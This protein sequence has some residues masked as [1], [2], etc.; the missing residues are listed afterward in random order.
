MSGAEAPR[1]AVPGR[2]LVVDDERQILRALSALLGAAGYSV[3]T[4]ATGA[5]A[6]QSAALSPPDAVVL[7]LRL[8]DLDG[9]E[10]CR[11]LR[12]WSQVPV[13]VV[14]VVDDEA[15]KVGALDAGADDY[16]TKPYSTA[17]LLAR[18]RAAMRRAAAPVGEEPQVS[19]G[20]VVVDLGR[21]EVR[22]GGELLHLTRRE[23]GLLAELARHP[24]RLLT[25]SMLLRAVW[26]PG[27]EE[28]SHYLHVHMSTL[29]RKLERDPARPRHLITEVGVGYRLRVD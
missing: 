26:G 6:L 19:F 13:V 1:A 27:A 11:R 3:N 18:L 10:V 15:R 17:E 4:A 7:D 28:E 23:Y 8:P 22:R 9:V 25:R 21:R 5:E 12:E 2:V 14:S 29:R 20:D 24:G 16:V